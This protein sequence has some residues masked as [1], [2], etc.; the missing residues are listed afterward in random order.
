MVFT[1]NINDCPCGKF[2]G[3]PGQHT[4][5]YNKTEIVGGGTSY[6]DKIM[7]DHSKKVLLSFF[8]AT[9]FY[10]DEKVTVLAL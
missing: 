8:L 9:T 10:Q 2:K 3:C 4:D 6:Q 7:T 1:R 5:R